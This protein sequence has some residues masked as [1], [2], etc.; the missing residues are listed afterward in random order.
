MFYS[1]KEFTEYGKQQIIVN[2]DLIKGWQIVAKGV[3]KFDGK[4]INIRL[5]RCIDEALKKEFEYA[6]FNFEIR[7][8][9]AWFDLTVRD[10]DNFPSVRS[11]GVTY[12]DYQ[13]D[14]LAPDITNENKRIDAEA[15][16]KNIDERIEGLKKHNE[17]LQS[18]IDNID[19][20]YQKF[21]AIENQIKEF[22]SNHSAELKE[23]CKF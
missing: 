12:V 19:S 13:S 6:F 20:I 8:S 5:T 16:I 11:S 3:K 10:N 18:E 7:Q 17:K 15:I 23:L 22:N 1:K 9:T 4:V 21:E 2:N 14:I